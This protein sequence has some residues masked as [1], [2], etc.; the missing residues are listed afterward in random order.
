M[1]GWTFKYLLLRNHISKGILSCGNASCL[2]I[3]K[4]FLLCCW[5]EIQ[6]GHHQSKLFYIGYYWNM[7][8]QLD[9]AQLV[10]ELPG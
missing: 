7:N 9:S 10:H 1:I 6:N 4:G 3:Y 5:P 8:K 2:T